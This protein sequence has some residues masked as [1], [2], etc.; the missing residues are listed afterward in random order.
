MS[1]REYGNGN[2][3]LSA[4]AIGSRLMKILIAAIAL[5]TIV[6]SAAPQNAV[7]VVSGVLR[8]KETPE[9][10]RG[11]TVVLRRTGSSVDIAATLARTRGGLAPQDRKGNTGEDGRFTIGDVPAG[12]YSIV[13]QDT[14]YIKPRNGGGPS[15]ITVISGTSIRDIDI[16]L[17]RPS[18]LSGT[19]ID[20]KR[21]PV[22]A[23]NV[24]LFEMAYRNGRRLLAQ[25]PNSV[26]TNGQGE[27][28]FSAIPPGEYFMRAQIIPPSSPNVPLVANASTTN[29]TS[30][31]PGT[32][33]AFGAVPI[34]V[35]EGEDAVGRDFAIAVDRENIGVTISGKL[36]T[37]GAGLREGVPL[38][39]FGL[40]PRETNKFYGNFYNAFTNIAKIP[41]QFEIRGIP[42]GLYDMF[43][44]IPPNGFTVRS[45]GSLYGRTPVTVSKNDIENVR[46]VIP[47][48]VDVSGKL[49]VKGDPAGVRFSQLRIDFV[50]DYAAA[51]LSTVAN[52]TGEFMLVQ[53]SPYFYRLVVSGLPE[54]VYVEDIFQ[55]GRSIYDSG[56]DAAQDSSD[57]RIVL[58]TNGGTIQG[59]VSESNGTKPSPDATVTLVPRLGKRENLGLY[60]KANTAQD[61]TFVIGGVLPGEYKLFA[62]ED[63]PDF[64][65]ENAEFLS[66][67]ESRGQTIT[68]VSGGRLS[69]QLKPIPLIPR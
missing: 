66:N 58:N 25:L 5:G 41:G 54:S 40:V 26:R 12:E 11:A 28:K 14:S 15:N 30:Y 35:H 10:I 19:L 16:H 29:S 9:P 55:K 38:S 69:V 33:D 61:G 47:A 8:S 7:S 21:Q 65:Y 18:T 24:Q 60:K 48:N 43:V 49:E 46:M 17:V 59:S 3:C 44:A 39:G 42:P 32:V 63:I 68:V 6:Q 27:Y 22:A 2:V 45:N 62:W 53:A 1:I 67:Y 64:A 57:L 34:L 56:L 50:V 20:S 31:Y 37:E 36:I 52:A 13:I 23:A 4:R 51:P